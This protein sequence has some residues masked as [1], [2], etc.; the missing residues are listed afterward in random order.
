MDYQLISE[1]LLFT[2]CDALQIVCFFLK[3]THKYKNKLRVQFIGN[4]LYFCVVLA[5]QPGSVVVRIGMLGKTSSG[6]D[7]V[8]YLSAL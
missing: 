7:A 8:M 3:H 1:R 6:F 2:R 5:D 4:K